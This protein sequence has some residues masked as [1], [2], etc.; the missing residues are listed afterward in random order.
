VGISEVVAH[1]PESVAIGVAS[2]RFSA[3]NQLAKRNRVSLTKSMQKGAGQAVPHPD[4]PC[5][6]PTQRPFRN[7]ATFRR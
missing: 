3:I 1:E 5:R 2:Q 7:P 6:G 4:E